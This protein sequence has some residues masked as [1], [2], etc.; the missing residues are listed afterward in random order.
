MPGRQL[1]HRRPAADRGHRALVDVVERLAGPAVD[2]G[3]AP[4]RR[5]G[6][7]PGSPPGRAGAAVR[8]SPSSMSATSPIGE[9]VRVAGD[10]QVGGHGDAPAAALGG[11]RARRPASPARTPAAHTTSRVRRPRCRRRTR[12]GRRPTSVDRGVEPHLDAARLEHL[13][14]VALALRA[15]RGQQVRRLLDQDHPGAVH[16]EVVEVLA[17]H[18]VDQL[19]HGAGHLDAGRPAADDRRC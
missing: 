14:G 2:G 11:A 17:Q 19:G 13:A 9:R 8:P 4:A 1:G 10:R 5:R 7:R 3:A 12:R 15:E 18:L 16:V 6:R